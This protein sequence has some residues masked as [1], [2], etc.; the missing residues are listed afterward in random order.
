MVCRV[1]DELQVA[2]EALRKCC[3]NFSAEV[4]VS[5]ETIF[6][7]KGKSAK[8]RAN[9]KMQACLDSN[10]DDVRAMVQSIESEWRQ[11]HSKVS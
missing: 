2:R 3:E 4:H 9:E 10:Y 1:F 7:S 8:A 5:K 11:R 6:K